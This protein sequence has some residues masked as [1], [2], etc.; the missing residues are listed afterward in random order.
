[1]KR[2]NLISG[3]V[4]VCLPCV[5]IV[6]RAQETAIPLARPIH[7]PNRLPVSGGSLVAVL[8]AGGSDIP[9]GANQPK[10]YIPASLSGKLCLT[11]ASRDGAYSA[12]AEYGVT[13]STSKVYALTFHSNYSQFRSIKVKDLASLAEVKDD[14]SSAPS[15]TR[16]ILPVVWFGSTPDFPIHLLLLA[17][18]Y[19]ARVSAS[20]ANAPSVQCADINGVGLTAVFDEECFIP[21][22][23][24]QFMKDPIEIDIINDLAVHQPPIRILVSVP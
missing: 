3:L 9:V 1:M 4:L 10:V 14:C 17:N 12:T 5:P 8:G 24:K 23:W 11:I 6:L 2:K 13:Q 18:Q 16:T 19:D 21:A 15:A 7:E 22:P 20:G